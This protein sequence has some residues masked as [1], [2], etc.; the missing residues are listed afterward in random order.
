VADVAVAA[1]LNVV[2]G[3]KLVSTPEF[4]GAG[5]V[6]P[7]VDAELIIEDKTTVRY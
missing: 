4:V 6:G 1:G 3:P 2:V 5:L 7:A